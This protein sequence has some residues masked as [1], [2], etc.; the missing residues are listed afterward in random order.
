VSGAE[1]LKR[2]HTGVNTVQWAKARSAFARP[3]KGPAATDDGSDPDEAVYRAAWVWARALA[4]QWKNA[5]KPA[6][7]DRD[8]CFCMDVLL[9]LRLEVVFELMHGQDETLIKYFRIKPLARDGDAGKPIVVP[10]SPPSSPDHPDAGGDTSDSLRETRAQIVT[11]PVGDEPGAAP[12]AQD[13]GASPAPED[14]PSAA[15]SLAVDDSGAPD[16][17]R[18]SVGNYAG[19]PSSQRNANSPAIDTADGDMFD[20]EEIVEDEDDNDDS[21]WPSSDQADQQRSRLRA[22]SIAQGLD[23]S[24]G[25]GQKHTGSSQ[26]DLRER[27]H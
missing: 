12:E 7:K 26:A 16:Q 4:T 2:V 5:N 9:A 22:S 15:F 1:E 19:S 10:P 25:H 3:S 27:A 8:T 18:R 24:S 13:Q 20:A 14:D 17:Q 23:N 21:D 6:F 11:S